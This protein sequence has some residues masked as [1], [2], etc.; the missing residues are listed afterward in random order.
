MFWCGR[1]DSNPHDFHHRNLNPARLPVP[2]RPREPS[3]ANLD[4]RPGRSGTSAS[5]LRVWLYSNRISLMQQKKADFELTP[6]YG[7]FSP[8]PEL[9]DSP[10]RFRRIS[11]AAADCDSK[12]AALSFKASQM[13][14]LIARTRTRLSRTGS[15][16]AA[17]DLQPPAHSRLR[18]GDKR[19]QFGRA[20][21]NSYRSGWISRF[22]GAC[23]NPAPGSRTQRRDRNP[24]I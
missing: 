13:R 14:S 22:G 12:A 9:A 19:R 20:G 16:H 5:P 15:T 3:R 17:P 10:R 7:G 23:G 6:S 11:P 4:A 2:P 18:P 24:W 21:R 1:R 8:R